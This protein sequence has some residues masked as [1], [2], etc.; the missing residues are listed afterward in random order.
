M[1]PAANVAPQTTL[2]ISHAEDKSRE[3]GPKNDC[4][5]AGSRYFFPLIKLKTPITS[6][7]NPM[8]AMTP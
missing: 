3:A 4:T 7:P 1:P 2:V 6:N 5:V 8:T